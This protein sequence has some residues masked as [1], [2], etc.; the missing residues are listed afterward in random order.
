MTKRNRN[1]QLANRY[2]TIKS[3][4]HKIRRER[5][6]AA[7]NRSLTDYF[8]NFYGTHEYDDLFKAS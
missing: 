5:R 1:L 7:R 3:A 4:V 8:Q 2:R 6:R